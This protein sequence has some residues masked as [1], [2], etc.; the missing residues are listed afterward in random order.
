MLK[1]DSPGKLANIHAKFHDQTEPPK[2]KLCTRCNKT[3]PNIVIHFWKI[4]RV[5]FRDHLEGSAPTM[6]VRG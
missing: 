4:H 6:V 1:T 2:P 5:E 3:F